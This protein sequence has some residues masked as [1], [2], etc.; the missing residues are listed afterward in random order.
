MVGIQRNKDPE[1]SMKEQSTS[2][3]VILEDRKHGRTGKFPVFYDI[4]TGDYLEPPA[5]FLDS[6]CESLLEWQDYVPSDNPQG[7]VANT[8]MKPKGNQMLR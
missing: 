8:P 3:F 4:A 6:P 7:E 2:Y 1:V 5:G